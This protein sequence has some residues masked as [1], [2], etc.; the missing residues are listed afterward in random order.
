MDFY[1]MIRDLDDEQIK[2]LLSLRINKARYQAKVFQRRYIGVNCGINPTFDLNGEQI[3]DSQ[4]IWQGFIPEDV[5]IIYSFIY[6]KNGYT[7]NNG[8]YYYVDD[9]EYLYEFARYIKKIEI[10]DEIEFLTYVYQFIS[11]Y[12]RGITNQSRHRSAMNQPLID[13]EGK[14]VEPTMGH[15]FSDFKGANNAECSEYSVMAQNILSIFGY[16]TIYCEGSVNTIYGKGGHAFNVMIINSQPC[17]IDFKIPVEIYALDSGEISMSPFIGA[18]NSFS[19]E[20]LR[21]HLLRQIPYDFID[22]YYLKTNDNIHM[23]SN[24]AKRNYIAG[25]LEYYKEKNSKLS[26]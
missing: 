6:D 8:C 21:Q 23:I 22:Y 7:V 1:Y 13:S 24:G 11:N 18:I 3:L 9:Q 4:S 19:I 20:S 10:H 2:E 14:N 12:F 15:H 26:K 5:R 17:I 16:K 25:N